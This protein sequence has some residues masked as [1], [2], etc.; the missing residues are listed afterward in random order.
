MR[1][2]LKPVAACLEEGQNTGA[3]AFTEEIINVS[4]VIKQLN[5]GYG[6]LE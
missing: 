2:A 5:V 3:A 6:T 4:K 1:T